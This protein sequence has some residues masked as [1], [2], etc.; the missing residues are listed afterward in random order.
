M[1][2]ISVKISRL[3]LGGSPGEEEHF[4]S[5]LDPDPDP[6]FDHDLDL[7][8]YY[9]HHLICL[10]VLLGKPCITGQMVFVRRPEKPDYP[11]LLRRSG[12]HQCV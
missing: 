1:A 8:H 6:D 3:S 12:C 7:D 9:L 10:I 11:A 4:S 2:S 5:E